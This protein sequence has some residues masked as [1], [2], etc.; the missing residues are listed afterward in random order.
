MVTILSLAKR[1]SCLKPVSIISY[2]QLGK[3]DGNQDGRSQ[4]FDYPTCED[5]LFDSPIIL[6]LVILTEVCKRIIFRGPTQT[7]YQPLLS[8]DGD[9]KGKN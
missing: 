4:H 1:N 8:V 5:S 3:D 2:N 7:A 9:S 6:H